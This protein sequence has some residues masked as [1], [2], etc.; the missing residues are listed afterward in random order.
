M[1]RIK[2]LVVYVKQLP[3]PIRYS[4]Y[5]YL[6]GIILY[7]GIASYQDASHYLRLY[8][9]NMLTDNCVKTIKSVYNINKEANI[10]DWD[11]VKYGANIHM[12]ER[13]W[14][15]IIFPLSV[16][17]NLIPGLVLL[18]NKKKED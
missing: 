12:G 1:N 7:N 2:E 14:D 17:N 4:T 11:V 16:V 3:T 18:L 15:S 8:N 9:N 13:L 10:T 6:G 5:A